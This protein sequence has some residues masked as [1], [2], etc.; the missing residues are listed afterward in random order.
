MRINGVNV[1]VLHTELN[2]NGIYPYPVFNYGD[3]GDFTFADNTDMTLVQSIIDAHDPTPIPQPLSDIEKL[4]LEQAQA[5]A[6]LVQL[7]MMMGGA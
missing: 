3:Y 2:N 7:I 6:E 5:N 4:R 1:G